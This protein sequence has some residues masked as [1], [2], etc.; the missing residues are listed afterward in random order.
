ML[1]Q[2]FQIVNLHVTIFI[3]WNFTIC[4]CS[5]KVTYE[6]RKYVAEGSS[7][8][9][10]C[11]KSS[12][13][14][15]KWTRNGLSVDTLGPDFSVIEENLPDDGVRMEL[16]VKMA[17]WK[18][19]GHYKCDPLSQRSHEIEIVPSREGDEE[20][21]G[22]PRVQLKPHRTIKLVCEQE[23][24]A[25]FPINCLF[26]AKKN[27]IVVQNPARVE[28]FSRQIRPILNRNM[29]L[30]CK[31]QGFPAPRVSWF[32][33]GFPIEEFRLND[34]RYDTVDNPQG[35]PGSVLFIQD[36]GYDDNRQI[37]C[38]ADN[39]D[40][41]DETLAQLAVRGKSNSKRKQQESQYRFLVNQIN[42]NFFAHPCPRTR[43]EGR[44]AGGFLL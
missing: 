6:G 39:I 8:S 33:D 20:M 3:I 27:I 2:A 36:V 23:E 24:N 11:I 22:Q 41:S 7:F 25:V 9:I 15:P 32:I 21:Q 1:K 42:G 14:V 26:I 5:S 13:G 35:M 28:K 16:R 10:F 40:G 31:V 4:E 38:I 19:R 43:G 44:R 29:S 12:Y 30:E 18:H 17:L 37:T 34:S